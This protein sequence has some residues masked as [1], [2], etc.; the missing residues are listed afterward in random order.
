VRIRP[1]SGDA[2][3]LIL[4]E[5]LPLHPGD[6]AILRDPGAR[7]V[8]SG[9]LV[10]DIDPP[11]LRRRG[12]AK[13]R[14]EEL[15]AY[16]GAPDLEVEVTRRGALRAA[17]AGALGLDVDRLAEPLP[18]SVRRVGEWF[19]SE[20]TWA[21]WCRRLRAALERQASADPLEPTLSLEAARVAAGLPDRSLLPEMSPDAGG[22]VAGGRVGLAGVRP[23]LGERAETGLRA[24]EA[25]LAEDPFAAPE[26][27]ELEAAGLRQREIAA[28]ARSGRVL[29]LRDDVLLLP[30][31]GALAMRVLAAL[32]QPF[33]TSDARQALGSTRRVVIPLLE[34]LDSR[35]WT[36]RVD[37]SHRRVRR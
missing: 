27:H 3:R 33:T 4:R 32:P 5:P 21:A 26:A 8:V 35:G 20:E 17:E 31:A 12:A 16:T 22:E 1:L 30:T 18:P 15:G 29:R 24:I 7:R 13:R 9:V 37:G 11:Q 25:S 14:G 2:A 6:R 19:V 34:H 23:S 28:A 36:Q 10:V